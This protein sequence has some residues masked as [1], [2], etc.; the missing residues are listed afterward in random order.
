MGTRINSLDFWTEIRT[1]YV[2]LC[3][4]F[5]SIDDNIS[6]HILVAFAMNIFVILTRL[7]NTF[8]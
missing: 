7:F 2:R 1:D 5:D 6:I 4:L 3:R 8:Q